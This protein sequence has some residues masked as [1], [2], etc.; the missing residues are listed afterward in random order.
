MDFAEKDTSQAGS[1]MEKAINFMGKLFTNVLDDIPQNRFLSF[2]YANKSYPVEYFPISDD[3]QSTGIHNL[4]KK[5]FQFKSESNQND[6]GINTR[7][8]SCM[9][10]ISSLMETIK[11][12]N[13]LHLLIIFSEREFVPNSAESKLLEEILYLPLTILFIGVNLSPNFTIANV[14]YIPFNDDISDLELATSV[15][16]AC[17][18]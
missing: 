12:S 14:N 6:S 5:Y 17:V 3:D 7:N 11:Q 4:M 10:V 18:F 9:S 15:L 1:S 2:G 13:T 8:I 16:K